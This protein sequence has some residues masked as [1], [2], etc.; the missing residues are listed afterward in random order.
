MS[1]FR[2]N[3]TDAMLKVYDGFEK[4]M[5]TEC[6]FCLDRLKESNIAGNISLPHITERGTPVLQGARLKMY[7]ISDYWYYRLQKASMFV[8]IDFEEKHNL[9]NRYIG[10][11]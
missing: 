5:E 7:A 10:I 4:E 9:N 11:K 3:M 2:E 1:T 8:S 6:L